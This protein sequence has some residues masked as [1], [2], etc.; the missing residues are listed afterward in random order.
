[1]IAAV[2][3]N[4]N[5]RPRIA[6]VEVNLLPWPVVAVSLIPMPEPVSEGVALTRRH[7]IAGVHDY[8]GH[9]PIGSAE[10]A[11]VW[12]ITRLT[13]SPEGFVT[14]AQTATGAA[15]T[16]RLTLTYN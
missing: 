5:N 4:L 10:A 16:D 8:C 12:T 11:A 13:I 15:W 6:A 14:A 9:A 7:D 3:V 1:M 2:D